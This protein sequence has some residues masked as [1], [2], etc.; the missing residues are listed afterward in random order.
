MSSNAPEAVPDR[1]ARPVQPA[2]IESFLAD[3]A[4]R[5]NGGARL[6][7]WVADTETFPEE[8]L[9]VGRAWLDEDERQQASSAVR[10]E[11]RRAYE[12]AHAAARL[13]VGAATLTPPEKI[14][15]GRHPC[16]SCGEPHGRPRPEGAAVE[17]SVSHTPGQV[18]IAV[19]DVPVGVDVERHPDDPAALATSL[20]RLL[21]PRETQEV[22]AADGEDAAV[23]FSRAMARTTAY[24][25]GLG[26]GLSQEPHLHY[27]GTD[28]APAR[29]IGEWS[30]RDVLVPEGYG[31]ALALQ[32]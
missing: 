15:W 1:S 12:I 9:E 26:I 11:L 22:V 4:P 24:L 10:G 29:T 13:V 8:E 2:T 32:A 17:F 19:A 18:L 21:H 7:V 5:A 30:I 27:L 6:G 20:S 28:P 14:V 3:P 31:A 16:P 23:R 25:K